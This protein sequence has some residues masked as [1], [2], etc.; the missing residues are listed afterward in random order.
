[1]VDLRAHSLHV[2]GYSV[3][4][5]ARMPLAELREHLFSIP[6]HPEWIPYR[7]SY[8]NE[9]WGFCVTQAVLEALDEGDYEV[10]VD[11]SLENGRLTYGECYLP[12]ETRGR[13]AD[14]GP[15]LPP[16]AL[17]RQPFGNRAVDLPRADARD[18]APAP[19][20][21]L[22]LRA[23]DDRR[24]RMASR[25]PGP[26]LPGEARARPDLRRRPGPRDL[27]TLAAR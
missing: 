22:S 10:V 24:D 16:V 17:Q 3:P 5:R 6:E 21:P 2:V 4:V 1:M 11:S 18:A 13:G 27:Q 23:R 9:T 19:L 8:Y 7:T 25:E 26:G 20:L 14:L 15:R 12:G